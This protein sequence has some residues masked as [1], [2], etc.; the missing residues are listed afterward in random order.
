MRQ[1]QC[2]LVCGIPFYVLKQSGFLITA[3][4]PKPYPKPTVIESSEII[5]LNLLPFCARLSTKIHTDR[6]SYH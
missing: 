2:R 6:R 4:S 1:D 5:P 3:G